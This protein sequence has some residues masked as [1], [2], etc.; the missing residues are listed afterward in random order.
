M[1]FTCEATREA[2]VRHYW[3]KIPASL[4]NLCGKETLHMSVN[5]SESI[6]ESKFQKRRPS[7]NLRFKLTKDENCEMVIF[8]FYALGLKMILQ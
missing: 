2:F 8:R 4:G 5:L 7:F 6:R 1:F 3:S